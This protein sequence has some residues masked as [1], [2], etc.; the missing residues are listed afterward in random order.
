MRSNPWQSSSNRTAGFV[1][2]PSRTR[3]NGLVRTG[4][5]MMALVVLS[6][7]PSIKD[8]AHRQEPSDV[9]IG[10][11]VFGGLLLVVT[12]R[13]AYDAAW[14]AQR[15]TGPHSHLLTA[16]TLTGWRTVDLTQLTTI[17][18]R[19]TNRFRPAL[20]YLVVTDANRVR[21]GIRAN[22]RLGI[23]W[24]REAVQKSA[25]PVRVSRAAAAALNLHHANKPVR[26]RTCRNGF[27]TLYLLLS[28]AASLAAYGLLIPLLLPNG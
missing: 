16:K 26:Y 9:A 22:D 20:D 5:I 28:W 7:G 8:V 21:L 14:P 6:Y 17:R 2:L 10:F 27:P 12:C 3:R 18:Y 11:A 15:G 23:D 25:T 19:L 13:I 24:L 1:V 4:L